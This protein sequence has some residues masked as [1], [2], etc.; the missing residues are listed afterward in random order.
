MFAMNCVMSRAHIRSRV[1]PIL[2]LP[3][4]SSS[5]QNTAGLV[6][7]IKRPSRSDPA[8]EWNFTHERWEIHRSPWRHLRHIGSITNSAAFQRLVFPDLFLVGSSAVAV[9]YW[10]SHIVPA[11]V[12]VATASNETASLIDWSHLEVSLPTLPF[13][14]CSVA[15]GLLVTFRTNAAYDRY[16]E[17]RVLWGEIINSSRDLLRQTL[18]WIPPKS[19]E[20]TVDHRARIFKLIQIFPVCLNF[21]LTT[22]GG[23]HMEEDSM[24]TNQENFEKEL[25]NIYGDAYEFDVDASRILSSAKKQSAPLVTLLLM[26]DTLNEANSKDEINANLLKEMDMQL[27]RLN[28]ALGACERILKTPIPTSYT[29]HTSR[30]LATW[31]NLLPLALWPIVGVGSIPAAVLISFAFYGIEDIGVQIEEPFD[32]LPLRQ[33]CQA[34]QTSAQALHECRE[35]MT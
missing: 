24:E 18:G 11:G 20:E 35:E 31:C 9:S 3:F 22:N 13:T 27:K 7:F 4:S 2:Q 33:Y 5:E 23:F 14:V 1:A 15:M 30:F 21:H 19:S 25:R 6:G 17:A 32:V 34:I 12:K 29:R 16:C 28:M 26:S 10:N 8:R